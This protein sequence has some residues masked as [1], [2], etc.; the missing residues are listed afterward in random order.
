MCGRMA[1][2]SAQVAHNHWVRGSNPCAPILSWSS[3][4]VAECNGLLIR[5]THIAFRGFKSLLLRFLWGRNAAVACLPCKQEV[6]GSIPFVSNFHFFLIKRRDHTNYTVYK[7][8]NTKENKCY[9][10]VT[11]KALKER[12][13]MHFHDSANPK[14]KSRPLYQAMSIYG[15]ESFVIEPLEVCNKDSRFVC[16]KK[17]IEKLDTFYH[18]YNATKGG[19]GKPFIDHDKVFDLWNS[20]FSVGQIAQKLNVSADGVRFHL[21]SIGIPAAERRRRNTHVEQIKKPVAQLDMNGVLMNVFESTSEA[22]RH[23]QKRQTSHISNV[24]NG[25]RKSA[26]GYVWKWANDIEVWGR[27][28][29][30]PRLGRGERELESRH[31]DHKVCSIQTR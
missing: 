12:L 8:T 28:S 7:I 3:S 24:C 21:E 4:I 14:M 2:R 27:C 22:H 13:K 16:E 25:S 20:G 26:F 29:I 30:P 17:W 1:Q 15:T 6:E 23:L 18:G 11:S 19:G 31:L 9:V 10:G 5:R